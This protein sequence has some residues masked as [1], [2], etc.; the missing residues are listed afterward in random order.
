M[1]V[2]D[3]LK[4]PVYLYPRGSELMGTHSRSDGIVICIMYSHTSHHAS[5]ESGYLSHLGELSI[6]ELLRERRD[7]LIKE[8]EELETH[9]GSQGIVTCL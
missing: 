5:L 2:I 3:R 7:Q 6:E 1:T 4:K 8:M 9:S